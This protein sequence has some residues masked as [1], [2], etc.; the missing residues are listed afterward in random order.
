[1][2]EN[3]DKEYLKK[4]LLRAAATLAGIAVIFYIGYQIWHKVTAS[5]KYEPATPYTYTVKTTGEGYVFRSEKVIE[6]PGEGSIVPS[7]DSGTKISAGT[8]VA[9]LY[10]SSAED[11]RQKLADIEAQ[12]ALLALSAE[13]SL[14][15]RDVSK[16]DIETYDIIAEI[17]RNVE[18]GKYAEAISHEQN[19]LTIVTRRNAAAGTSTDVSSQIEELKRKRD[20][21]TAGLGSL[22]S[23]VVTPS[24]GWYYTET[25]GYETVFT[26]E[27]IVNASYADF[28]DIIATNSVSTEKDAGKT[29]TSSTWRFVCELSAESLDTKEI[30]KDYTIYFPHNRGMKIP[31]TLERISR[32]GDVGIAVFKSDKIPEGFNFLRMQSYELLENEYTG[33]RIPKSAVRIVD[34]QMGVYVLTGEVVHFR[35]IDVITEYENTYIVEMDH[36][37]P[38]EEETKAP[39]AADTGEVAQSPE[40]SPGGSKDSDTETES[41]SA[42]ETETAP[43]V[44][45]WLGLN[46]NVIT[47][48]KGLSDGR[49]ITNIN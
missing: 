41:E 33:F 25:D 4:V 46:E 19:L 17:R 48:G 27:K 36:K 2:L 39:S 20:E 31:M 21:I 43:A 47:S 42:T 40:W 6:S 9:N 23:S 49:I 38:V 26:P 5:V 8:I 14:T 18:Q 30:G 24:S 28:K 37:E 29:V 7:V 32:G 22:V 13:D 45:K 44:Y 15:N 1:M 10:S 34:G 3:Y 11:E 35:L 12:L 16:L